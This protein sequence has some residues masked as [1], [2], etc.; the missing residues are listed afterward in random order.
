MK[1]FTFGGTFIAQIIFHHFLSTCARECSISICCFYREFMLAVFLPNEAIPGS[2]TTKRDC[3]DIQS[4][5]LGAKMSSIFLLSHCQV[6][7]LIRSATL[8]V[9]STSPLKMGLCGSQFEDNT[10]IRL[11]SPTLHLD[12]LTTTSLAAMRLLQTKD[13]L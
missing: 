7:L 11:P 2:V 6:S 9:W 4:I 13:G 10:R 1:D 3:Q 12:P 8:Y 5:V